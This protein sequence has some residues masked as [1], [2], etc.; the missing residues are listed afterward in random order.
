MTAFAVIAGQGI[1][2]YWRGILI[3][4]RNKMS[5]AR[6]QLLVWTLVVLSAIV[7]AGI[8][9]GAFSTQAPLSIQIP[10]ELWVLLGIS[11]ASAVAAPAVLAPK[12][13]K[14]PDLKEVMQAQAEMKRGDEAVDIDTMHPGLILRNTSG[15]HARWGDLLKGD[16]WGN[17]AVVDLGKLQM[18]FFTFVLALGYG[19]AIGRLFDGA[20]GIA[21]LPVVDSSMN[22]LLGISH[23]G[24]LAN[25]VVP[26]SREVEATSR[27]TTTLQASAATKTEPQKVADGAASSQEVRS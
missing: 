2:G 4:N 22:T 17:A 13:K 3:D 18:F 8:T 26:H 27:P 6:L 19:I 15:K 23:T 7:T 12:K 1:T 20:G 21:A 16:E 10:E 11:T 14:I 9:N 25:K 24:Y 5:L